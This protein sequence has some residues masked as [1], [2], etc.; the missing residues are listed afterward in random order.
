MATKRLA[1]RNATTMGVFG[2]GTQATTHITYTSQVR[3]LEEVRV[4][5]T[6][7]GR[8][9]SF[10]DR[11]DDRVDASVVAVDRP[12]AAV[13]GCDVVTTATNA[14]GPVFDGEWLE[15][16]TH[17]NVVTPSNEKF[18]PRRE[19]D[20][21]TL[22]RSDVLVVNSKELMRLENHSEVLAMQRGKINE[23]QVYDLG[24]LM[25]EEVYG[26]THESQ[27]TYHGNNGGMGIQFA[28]LGRLVYERAKEAGRGTALDA[29]L[30]MQYDEDLIEV[31]NRG[32]AHRDDA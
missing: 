10:A 26:R 6:N 18:F 24:E 32:F 8:R 1:P 17:V 21:T 13:E 14:N 12:R 11:M 5:S 22:Q 23:D 29:D 15:A 19:M 28:A 3:D 20:D 25:I 9:E 30:F 31:R 27:I 2:S 7:E 16:G 4:Y